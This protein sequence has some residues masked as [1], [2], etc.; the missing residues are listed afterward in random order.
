MIRTSPKFKTL[1]LN[2]ILPLT[3][4]LSL[5]SGM[6]SAQTLK[7][8]PSIKKNETIL[9]TLPNSESQTGNSSNQQP[10]DQKN[11]PS[12]G[13]LG[14]PVQS[15]S[16]AL[17]EKTMSF[18]KNKVGIELNS[19]VP[20][21]LNLA[22]N[23]VRGSD[24]QVTQVTK[25]RV[26]Q[27]PQFRIL[28]QSQIR[29]SS[30]DFLTSLAFLSLEREGKISLNKTEIATKQLVQIYEISV[31]LL[32]NFQLGQ[33]I[34]ARLKPFTGLSL[35]PTWIQV[36]ESSFSEASNQFDLSMRLEAG[37]EWRPKTFFGSIENTDLS[38]SLAAHGV[39]DLA[40][41]NYQGTGLSLGMR[42]VF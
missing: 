13:P 6:A 27:V 9:I 37:L 23:I 24:S 3:M 14:T 42:F 11:G 28:R 38:F 29:E 39:R 40:A 16:I 10:S 26:R 7:R 8:A 30:F 41:Y 20:R 19:F 17:V 33:N 36:Q 21:D 18:K 31:G 4:A 25:F 5:W 22:T 32:K 34:D 1:L 12:L 15:T 35:V 2:F